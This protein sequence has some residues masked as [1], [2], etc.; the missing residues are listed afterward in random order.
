MNVERVAAEA[1]MAVVVVYV[2]TSVLRVLCARVRQPAVI[3]QIAGGILL[4]P[5]ALGR[6][7]P[8]L[9]DRLFPD[10]L[11][12][13]LTVLSDVGLSVFL[14]SVGYELSVGSL[15]RQ[16]RRIAYVTAGGVLLP[17]AMGGCLA[18]VMIARGMSGK[19]P[20]AATSAFVLFMIVALS[21]TAVPVLASIIRE[22]NLMAD[23]RGTV[24]M[25][26]AGIMDVVGWLVLAAAVA[27]AAPSHR[28]PLTAGLLALA[29][30]LVAFV[31]V[32]PLLAMWERSSKT[33]GANRFLL[34]VNLAL[35]SAWCTQTIGLHF[36]FGALV[37]GLVV[38][39]DRD[40]LPSP[41]L[42]RTSKQTGDILMPL[43]FVATGLQTDL[44]ALTGSDWWLLV[45][46]CALAAVGKVGGGM[47]AGRLGG[48]RWIDATLIG[49]LLNTRGLTEL[50]ALNVGHEAGI[51]TDRLYS[52]LVM[53]ALLTTTMTGP[54]SKLV[55]RYAPV[56]HVSPVV[57]Q[58]G[59]TPALAGARG[60][61]AGG[62]GA[63]TPPGTVERTGD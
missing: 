56:V 35:L 40:G 2:L 39:R 22:H 1:F 49:V 36:F 4:G 47:L 62:E 41:D 12:P 11:I 18:W 32:R 33:A 38:P 37:A 48:F 19:A 27:V 7:S 57:A 58:A 15:R 28:S 53:M 26:S 31:V 23:E 25:A 44:G 54:L 10:E 6:L 63:D 8:W 24:A 61:S 52:V 5:T 45:A 17:M 46:V 21:V 20:D 29:F 16:R 13:F 42:L 9:E 59:H 55:T 51:I 60:A 30:L 3:G 34:Y 50:I 43:F 14:F